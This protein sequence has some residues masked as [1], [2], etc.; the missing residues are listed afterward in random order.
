MWQLNISKCWYWKIDTFSISYFFFFRMCVTKFTFKKINLKMSTK[1]T[2]LDTCFEYI[3][4]TSL[5]QRCT[6]VM[7]HLIYEFYSCRMWRNP[8]WTLQEISNLSICM[9]Y[10]QY[11]IFSYY[12]I[13]SKIQFQSLIKKKVLFRLWIS[14]M[15]KL[16]NSNLCTSLIMCHTV[17]SI[18]IKIH[19]HGDLF[20]T[21]TT[22]ATTNKA[23][24]C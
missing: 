3:V 2:W 8:E 23:V 5:D 6:Y 14:W 20:H 11:D 21:S 17:C 13:Q 1:C 18:T 16:I 22:T 24:N 15:R 4:C 12:S 7:C 9:Q 10:W 19:F